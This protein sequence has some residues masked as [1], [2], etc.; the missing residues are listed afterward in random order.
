MLLPP[1]VPIKN[2]K[3]LVS[4]PPPPAPLDFGQ[5]LVEQN[6]CICKWV[7]KILVFLT[8][9]EILALAEEVKW[10]KG[11]KTMQ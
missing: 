4:L 9:C 5:I 6:D 11:R 2:V 3:Q 7:F 1:T 8:P 10:K